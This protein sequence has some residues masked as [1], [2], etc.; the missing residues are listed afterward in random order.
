MKHLSQGRRLISALRS[1]QMGHTYLEMQMLG[2]ST[3]PQKRIVESLREDE[4]LVKGK[5]G[6][7]ITWRVIKV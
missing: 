2:I 5:R 6:N 1:K 7:L 4:R 3:S